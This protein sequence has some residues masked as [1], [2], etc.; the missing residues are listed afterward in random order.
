[1]REVKRP[2]P[3]AKAEPF[4]DRLRVLTRRTGASTRLKSA[5]RRLGFDL[6]RRHYY[7]PIPDLA[8]LPDDL[9]TRESEL[10]SVAF[11]VAAGLDFIQRE[12]A[13]YMAEYTPPRTPTG[14]PGDFYLENGFY[15]SVD[16][17]TLYAMVRRLAPRRIVE[18]GSG[19]S[20]LVIADARAHP[21]MG[22]SEH[23]VYDPHMRL[24]LAEPIAKRTTVQ[25][26]SATEIPLTV[27]ESLGAGDIL[28]VDTT[29][30]V[31]LGGDVNRI[32]LDVLPILS[33]GVYVHFHDIYLPWEYPREFLAERSFFWAEQYLLQAFLAF[34]QQFEILFGAHALQRRFP[35]ALGRLVP[36]AHPGIRPSALWLRRIEH[37]AP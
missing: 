19:M 3:P 2:R 36:S 11:D 23:L 28:F 26:V 13:P 5:V 33:P 4:S 37:Q 16:A 17:E 34:N 31:K 25:S 15:E 1:M 27:F 30:T 29:H 6:L 21:D 12:L 35:D 18:L 8:E 14:D 20:T 32:V 22:R 7:S 10:R 24:D 9:W